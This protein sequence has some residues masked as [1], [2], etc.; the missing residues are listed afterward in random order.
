MWA[1]RTLLP[2]LL[3]WAALLHGGSAHG[4]E[5]G[6][7]FN[8]IVKVGHRCVSLT[9][10]EQSQA[11]VEVAC[12]TGDFVQIEPAPGKPFVGT[13]GAAHRFHFTANAAPAGTLITQADPYIGAGTI[14]SLRIYNI[15]GETG[16]L[17][18]LVSF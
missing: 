1:Q 12:S 16:P 4:L 6:G 15:N 2:F 8:V 7:D 10:S 18:M 3:A 9:W 17:E 13:H 14:T 5:M 11:R